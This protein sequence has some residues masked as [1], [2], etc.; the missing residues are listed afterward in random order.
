MYPCSARPIIKKQ[1]KKKF[2]FQAVVLLL[3]AVITFENK[4]PLFCAPVKY[5]A[6]FP[7]FFF[8]TEVVMLMSREPNILCPLF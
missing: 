4:P 8:I 6:I 2:Y 7:D 5:K 1:T 3:F